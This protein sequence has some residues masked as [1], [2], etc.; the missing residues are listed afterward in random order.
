MTHIEKARVASVLGKCKDRGID[1]IDALDRSG[2]LLTSQRQA[3]VSAE[4]LSAAAEIISHFTVASLKIPNTALDMRNEI[5]K[6]LNQQAEFYAQQRDG[7]ARDRST[8]S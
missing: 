7:A 1:E 4:T 8:A 3:G 5:V 2:L 6:L